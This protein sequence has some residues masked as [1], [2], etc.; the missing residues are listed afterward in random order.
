MRRR[1]NA[2]KLFFGKNPIDRLLTTDTD[3]VIHGNVTVR[4]NVILSNDSNLEIDHLITDSPI[5][6]MNFEDLL[7][8]CHANSPNETIVVTTNKWF[9]NLTIAQ[10]IVDGDF[11]PMGESTGVIVKRLEDLKNGLR[12]KGPITF[13]SPFRI[14]NLT[15]SDTV[16]DIPSSSFGQQWLLHEGKQVS[17]IFLIKIKIGQNLK[18]VSIFKCSRLL[19]CHKISPMSL[20]MITFN[21]MV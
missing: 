5:F 16:N 19:R 15:V 7:N 9:Q 12:L 17:F 1:V 21:C 4:G 14:N 8:D 10:I 11:W 3:Q 13:T 2:E 18:I 6:G 20:L